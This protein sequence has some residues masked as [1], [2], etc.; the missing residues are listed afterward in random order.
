MADPNFAI[1]VAK[2]AAADEKTLV[3]EIGP[4]TGCLTQALLASHPQARVLAVEI[5][6]GLAALLRETFTEAIASKR[7]TLIEG[8]A[9]DGKHRLAEAWVAEAQ[10]I[11]TEEKRQRIVLCANLPYNAATPLLANMALDAQGLDV[12][13]AVATIQLELAER[14]FSPAGSP[15]YGALSA[16]LALRSTGSI[17]RKVGGGIFWPR[18]QVDSAVIGI[19][20]LPWGEA[21][22]KR[23][24]AQAFQDFLQKVFSQRRKMLRAVL[25][26]LKLPVEWEDRAEVRADELTPG[27]LLELFRKISAG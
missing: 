12:S 4:G 5:D 24:E 10:R 15:N 17:L 22:L 2:D 7:L 18:P 3:I 25:K 20:F 27:A 8:D 16:L 1:A 23:A 9:L 21:P 6:R 19:D 14:M 26:P 13:R 11:R